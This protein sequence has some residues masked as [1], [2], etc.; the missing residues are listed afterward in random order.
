MR[1][2]TDRFPKSVRFRCG[3]QRQLLWTLIISMLLASMSL[4]FQEIWSVSDYSHYLRPSDRTVLST[5]VIAHTA[6]SDT[7]ASLKVADNPVKKERSLDSTNVLNHDERSNKTNSSIQGTVPSVSGFSGSRQGAGD[8][9]VIDA[10]LKPEESQNAEKSESP[11]SDES[12][13][14]KRFHL[15][16]C[17][18]T[19]NEVP[20]I[21]EWIEHNR[22]MGVDR[23]IIYDDNSSDN[24][25]L[26]NDFYKER[27]PGFSILA[28]P[29]LKKRP[30]RNLQE[31]NLQ[32]CLE[33]YGNS[34][35]W[36]LNAD[37][38]EYLYSPYYGTLGDM[39]RNL[40]A[41]EREQNKHFSYITSVNLNF[42]S[43]GQQHRFENSLT[44]AAD[45]RV[46]YSNP[47]GLQ[48]ITDHVRRGPATAIFGEDEEYKARRACCF[49]PKN[50]MR[51]RPRGL[52]LM[53]QL[54]HRQLTP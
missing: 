33:T 4:F 10:I 17:T 22:M 35:E 46:V 16:V 53:H 25:L 15:T 5:T 21:V 24:A 39:L 11:I 7:V 26:L 6:V 50:P 8:L 20:Y 32:H 44:R 18:M 29:S 2:G 14:N 34:T 31:T 37:V 45:G 48:L 28:Q 30:W 54:W 43:S 12:V 51:H 49:E 19:K 38:D 36:L 42:G 52:A 1:L 3:S 47:C 27:A 13:D 23:I 41:M 9:Q 40:S